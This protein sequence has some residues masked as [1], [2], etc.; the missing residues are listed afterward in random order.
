ME[1]SKRRLCRPQANQPNGS[2]EPKAHVR[3]VSRRRT[4]GGI[5]TGFSFPTWCEPSVGFIAICPNMSCRRIFGVMS[6][7]DV[8]ANAKRLH[9]VAR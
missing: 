7:T 6:D 1:L 9:L 5:L 4:K 3:F 2:H 8:I